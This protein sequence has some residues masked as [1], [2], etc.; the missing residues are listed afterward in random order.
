MH[1]KELKARI[2]IAAYRAHEGHI[3]SAYS[4][5]DILWVLYNDVFKPN[6]D[7][8][9]LSKGHASLALY[10]VLADLDIISWKEFDNFAQ[11]DGM[12]GG[13]PDR[14]K[15]P[16]VTFSTGSLGHGL[17][18][19][20]GLAL[21]KKI[22]KEAGRV[23]CL[24]GDGECNEGSVWESLL[25]IRHLNLNNMTVIVDHNHSTDRALDLGDLRDKLETFG[26]LARNIDG[27]NGFEIREALGWNL[28]TCPL[29]LIFKTIKGRGCK[30][31]ED[32]P[33]WH[34]KTPNRSELNEI[35]EELRG[36][37][38]DSSGVL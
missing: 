3:A 32:N 30:R 12:L 2:A 15:V 22:K 13:H 33:E 10:A 1:I 7:A 18:M 5:L 31:M 20:V 6:Q 25:L 19:A 17:P 23:Y 28:S 35:L 27:H 11:Y 38:C 34:H 21:A 9:V 16:G 36:Y 4:I 24:I 37:P 8:F 26:F 29:A 14:L